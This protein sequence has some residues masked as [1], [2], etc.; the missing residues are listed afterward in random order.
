[1][2]KQHW[3][4]TTFR[5]HHERCTFLYLWKLVGMRCDLCV[6][7]MKKNKLHH[8]NKKYKYRDQPEKY[9]QKDRDSEVKRA[10]ERERERSV[11]WNG[12]ENVKNEKNTIKKAANKS[13]KIV[14]IA[15]NKVKLALINIMIVKDIRFDPIWRYVISCH[16]HWPLRKI[17]KEL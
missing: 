5:M 14:V 10:R 1:M 13:Y 17:E 11:E 15:H 8:I 2:F 6:H 9:K 4:L 16:F 12:Q 7:K 3:M